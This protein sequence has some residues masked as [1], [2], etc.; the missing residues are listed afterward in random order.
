MATPA[1]PTIPAPI[2]LR[3]VVSGQLPGEA[4]IVALLDHDSRVRATMSA[5]NLARWDN[6]W[7][8]AIEDVQ[9]AWR[10]LWKS[11]GWL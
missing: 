3:L 7:L 8:T 4:L 11:A 9:H 6:L 5:E 1:P 2:D 10:G